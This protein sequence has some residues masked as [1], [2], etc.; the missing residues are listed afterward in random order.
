[1][2]AEAVAAADQA[3][4]VEYTAAH[5]RAMDEAATLGSYRQRMERWNRAE[6][7][8]RAAKGALLTLDAAVDAWEATG[9]PNGF[10]SAAAC[11]VTAL[12][13]LVAVL[14]VV[15]VNV[16]QLV[17]QALTLLPVLVG[18]SSCGFPLDDDDPAPQP[19]PGAVQ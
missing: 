11:G 15:H 10:R 4:A 5:Q 1:V 14:E 16:P 6:E 8:L 7:A 18:D 19:V 3:V 12:R 13:E 9:S 2:S 17:Q